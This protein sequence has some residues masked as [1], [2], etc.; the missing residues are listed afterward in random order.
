MSA[1]RV[2]KNKS[3]VTWKS[4]K[5]TQEITGNEQGQIAVGGNREK[6]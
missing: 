3:Y 4:Q 1:K 6:E 5:K 2:R